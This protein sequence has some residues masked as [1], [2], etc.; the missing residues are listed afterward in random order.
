MQPVNNKDK[1]KVLKIINI[2]ILFFI[3]FYTF[4]KLVVG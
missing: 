2:F 4:P 3:I 1:N